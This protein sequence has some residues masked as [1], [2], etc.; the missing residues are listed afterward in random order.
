M[1]LLAAQPPDVCPLLEFL[2]RWNAVNQ[3]FLKDPIEPRNGEVTLPE[4][5]G[6]GMELDEGKIVER[7]ELQW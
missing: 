3:F 5:P 1:H 2:L 6:M 4:G 7:R